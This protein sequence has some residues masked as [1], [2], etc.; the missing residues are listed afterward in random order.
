MTV[1]E[2]TRSLSTESS[3]KPSD[4]SLTTSEDGKPSKNSTD[5]AVASTDRT[6]TSSGNGRH[7]TRCNHHRQLHTTHF[8]RQGG[9]TNHDLDLSSVLIFD[10]PVHYSSHRG[11]RQME[12]TGKP[13][14]NHPI[15]SG[16]TGAADEA[17]L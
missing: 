13:S 17:P 8:A 5:P 16:H 4:C 11:G 6:P 14:A 7:R 10:Q 9:D 12:Q 1:T 15:D 3:S 2:S